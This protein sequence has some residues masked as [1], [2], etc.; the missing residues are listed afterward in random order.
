MNKLGVIGGSGLETIDELSVDVRHKPHSSFGSA[1]GDILEGSLW[2]TTLLFLSRHGAG[3]KIAPHEI[4]Y[5]ANIH[6]LKELGATHLVAIAVV[7]GIHAD[8][9][10]GSFVIPNQIIDYTWGRRHTFTDDNG[11][12]NHIDFTE[13]YCSRL[14]R[15]LH[16][17]AEAA[18]EKAPSGTYGA[19]QGPRLE[20]AAEI[21]RLA[22]DGCDIVGMTGMPEAALAREAGLPYAQLGFVVNWA[23]G[24]T[25]NDIPPFNE[26]MELISTAR[27]RILKIL[28]N[29]CASE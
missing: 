7:G 23:A 10:P 14:R 1:S 15:R 16:A 18:G 17:A 29:F 22:R 24:V 3:H 8:L 11:S 28:E 21:K 9:A 20:T 4:N 25:N 12:V 13:P 5:R 19:T 27:P 2:N 6:R 26:L